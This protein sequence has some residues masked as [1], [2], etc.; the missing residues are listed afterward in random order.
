[1]KQQPMMKTK[2]MMGAKTLFY[3]ILSFMV[4]ESCLYT[5]KSAIKKFCIKDTLLI[6]TIIHDTIIVDSIQVDT[7]FSENIDSVYITKDKIE[8]RYFK[9]NG[10]V[11]LQ[12]KCKGDTIFYTKTI[13]QKIPCTTPK[14]I[15]YKQ[16]GA[17]YWYIMPFI[18]LFWLSIKYLHKL[19]NNG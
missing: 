5:K 17:D 14:L 11:Y 12:G 2:I 3:L 18:F 9:R 10:V 4:L 8:I 16:L 1:M 13:F 7:I 6:E 19:L 15:W